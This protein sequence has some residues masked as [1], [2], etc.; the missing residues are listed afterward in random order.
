MEEW[1]D[2]PTYEGWYQISNLGN[3]KSIE[4]VLPDGRHLRERVLKG[5]IVDGYKVVGLSKY[6]TRK[7]FYVHR[8]VAQAFVP[9]PKNLNEVDHIDT[10]RLNNRYDNLRW[11]TRSENNLNPITRSRLGNRKGSHISQSQIDSIIETLGK[12]VS[13]YYN[14]TLIYKFRSYGEV[15]RTSEEILGFKISKYMLNKIKNSKDCLYR[16][17]EFYFE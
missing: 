11:V 17:Y 1:K 8:L 5:S 13:V 12:H 6:G 9:N 10:I 2:I 3:V 15:E 16:G 4:R 14:Q 7:M